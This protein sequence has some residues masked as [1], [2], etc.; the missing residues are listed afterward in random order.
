MTR[1]ITF[2]FGGAR[3]A[4]AAKQLYDAGYITAPT[5]AAMADWLKLQ[6]STRLSEGAL[7]AHRVMRVIGDTDC[8]YADPANLADAE[9][10]EGVSANAVSAAGQTV[11]IVTGGEMV[12]PSWTWT[13]GPVFCGTGGALTQSIPAATWVRQIGVA[14][15]ADR[16]IVRLHPPIYTP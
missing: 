13:P 12:E 5:V 7:S 16:I 1:D 10:V 14:T 6:S 11:T 3:G 8:A 15:A 9:F 4:S 2:E